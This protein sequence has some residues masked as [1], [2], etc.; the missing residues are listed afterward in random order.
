[1]GSGE[2]IA[3]LPLRSHTEIFEEHFPYYLA[4]GMTYEQFW[5]QNSSLVIFYRKANQIK[6]Q[7]QNTMLWLQGQYFYDALGAISPILHA[8]AKQGTKPGKYTQKPYPITDSDRKLEAE[9]QAKARR[10]AF[11]AS[12]M[13][14][15]DQW[16]QDK[17]GGGEP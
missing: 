3:P 12:L 9:R 16:E 8:F 17:K 10:D 13:A 6:I 5:E 4:I 14:F 1:M 11:K 15:A 7:Q 2:K